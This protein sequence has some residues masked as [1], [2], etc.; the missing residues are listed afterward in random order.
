MPGLIDLLAGPPSSQM[1]EILRAILTYQT[2]ASAGDLAEHWLTK[3]D[4]LERLQRES[5]RLS[6]A[7]AKHELQANYGDDEDFEDDTND[8]GKDRM[9][10]VMGGEM[11]RR[12][13]LMDNFKMPA[14]ASP[15]LPEGGLSA[16]FKTA[17]ADL[18]PPMSFKGA[19]HGNQLLAAIRSIRR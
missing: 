5:L 19:T 17:Y 9:T 16:I 4:E 2:A 12:A 10:A 11:A 8:R 18:K 3:D 6:V 7:K 15:S 14:K 13:R 1:D